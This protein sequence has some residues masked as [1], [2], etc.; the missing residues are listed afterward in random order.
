MTKTI[1]I[2][3]MHRSG[4]SCLAGSLEQY[5]LYLGDVVNS[6]PHNK[7]GNKENSKTWDIND[8][9]LLRSGGA[10][11]KPPTKIN[12]GDEERQKRDAYIE[13]FKDKTIWGFKD[14]RTL[15]TLEFWLEGLPHLVLVGTFRHPLLVANSLEKRNGFTHDKSLKLWYDYNLILRNYALKAKF[16]LVC[17]E[18][19]NKKYHEQVKAVAKIIG[20][21]NNEHSNSDSFFDEALRTKQLHSET[22]VE[23]DSQLISL[24]EDL[25]RMQL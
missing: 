16:P 21:E 15:L 3:G 5:G 20:L 9:V 6:A 13:S 2:V 23:V 14:P 19:E 22:N 7:K 8:A 10:W 11:D 12:W 18:N 25:C 4:T 1:C 17:F 24:Y